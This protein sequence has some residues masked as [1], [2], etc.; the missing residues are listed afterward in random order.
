MASMIK[1]NMPALQTLNQLNRNNNLLAKSL[2][3]VSSGMKIN[4]AADD[5]SAYSISE[6]M[7]VQLRALD[8]CNDNTKTG[9]NMLAVAE[10]AID[11]Q[12]QLIKRMKE[13]AL[14]AANDTNTDLDRAI[15]QKEVNSRLMEL[16]SISYSTEYNGRQLLN[17][18][19]PGEQK[20][21]FNSGSAPVPNTTPIIDIPTTAPGTPTHNSDYNVNVRV[22]NNKFSTTSPVYDPSQVTWT[23]DP[24]GT[25]YNSGQIVYD[26]TPQHNPY[27][28]VLDPNNNNKPSVII[29]GAYQEIGNGFNAYTGTLA[30]LPL[31]SATKGS[32]YS[33]NSTMPANSYTVDELPDGQKILLDNNG[34]SNYYDFDFHNKLSGAILPTALDNQGFSVLC[35]A[36][37]Q[38][39]CVQFVASMPANTGTY[40]KDPNTQAECYMI[41][42][43]GLSNVNDIYNA[44]QQGLDQASQSS[45]YGNQILTP[46]H[47]VRLHFFQDSN[48]DNQ[49]YVTKDDLE[50]E[51]YDGVVGAVETTG[52][53]LPWQNLV[54]QG[55]TVSSQFTR[56]QLPNT[57]LAALFPEENATWDTEPKESDYPNPWPKGYEENRTWPP[58]WGKDYIESASLEDKRRRLWREEV[59]P[60]PIKGAI[61]TASCV[62]TREKALKFIT[63]LDQAL[64][65]LAHA[66]TTLGS[67][68]TRL[69]YMNDNIVTSHENTTAAESVIRD[70]DMAKEMTNYSKY[71]VLSQSAQSMLAQA[72]QNLGNSLNLLQ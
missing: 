14:D 55:D 56:L 32:S 20:T 69:G 11:N 64:K 26:G 2:Q 8:Q 21:S 30:S 44:L 31:S 7:R 1:N 53:K 45:K 54:I 27:Q 22:P 46:H 70:A 51:L 60:Y 17:G 25:S 52:G 28:V 48:G 42:I 72:N 4:S 38:F 18:I 71:N 3:K 58:E 19:I 63:S 65:Y 62:S 24:Q 57:T 41:G 36:C 68:D 39:V 50:L 49:C 43:A 9:T 61:S 10:G 29:G 67:Q 23:Q 59:W 34:D 40:N 35:D 16:N 12:I 33:T 66:A 13:I 6:K 5:A 15:M 37:D 47:N